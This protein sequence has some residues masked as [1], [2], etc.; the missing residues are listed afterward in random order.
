[1]CNKPVCLLFEK[2]YGEILHFQIQLVSSK[3]ESSLY[4]LV[5]PVK[6]N[7]LSHVFPRSSDSE[8]AFETP[9]S[10]TPVKAPPSP[11]QPPPD[12]A[13]AIV[14]DIAEQEIKP[15]LPLEDT[16]NKH[17][18]WD[19]LLQGGVC[20]SRDKEWMLTKCFLED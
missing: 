4:S 16:G 19:R 3:H 2:G 17:A 9:E 20:V 14:A 11:P 5:L 1:M 10:T 15:Q 18:V 12:T 7:S 6:G 8:E 13:V